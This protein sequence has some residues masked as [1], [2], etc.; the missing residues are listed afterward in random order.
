MVRLICHADH[1]KDIWGRDRQHLTIVV[2]LFV[3]I[4]WTYVRIY[5]H[6]YE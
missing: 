4:C 3:G 6:L 5:A 1:L 2:S